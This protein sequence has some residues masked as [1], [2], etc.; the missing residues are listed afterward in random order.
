M[1]DMHSLYEQH[2]DLST[3][4]QKSLGKA[5]AG[6]MAE[7]HTAFV[8]K[9]SKM[10]KDGEINVFAP[11]SFFKQEVY[12]SLSEQAKT[13]VDVALV[14]VADLLRH[15]VEFYLSKQT[16]DSSPQ[17]AQM[18]DQLWQMTGRLQEKYGTILKF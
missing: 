18:I 4:A 1:T 12:D 3:D 14:N 9:L 15:I 7:A 10:V 6:D 8:I 5:V 11:A 2:K 13:Q 17:L 16:P